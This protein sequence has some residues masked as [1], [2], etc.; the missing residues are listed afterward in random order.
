MHVGYIQAQF[1]QK[2][3]MQV[4]PSWHSLPLDSSIDGDNP[5]HLMWIFDNAVKRADEYSIPGV[6]YRMTQGVLSIWP[7]ILYTCNCFV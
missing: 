4:F 2:Q 5:D 6:T 3:G 1:L 7:V